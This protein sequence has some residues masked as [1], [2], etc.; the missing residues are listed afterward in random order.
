MVYDNSIT[1][2]FFQ[3]LVALTTRVAQQV[4]ILISLEKRF[5]FEDAR[6]HAVEA[7]TFELPPCCMHH[8]CVQDKLYAGGHGSSKP[9]LPVFQALPE[10]GV[11]RQL[12][13]EVD[14]FAKAA[15]CRFS[16]EF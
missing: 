8:V 16:A 7:A 15:E 14:I 2:A 11:H 1:D 6:T 4:C 10:Q 3:C 13:Q 5:E 12:G 9:R